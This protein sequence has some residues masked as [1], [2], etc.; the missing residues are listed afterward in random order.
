MLT[1][2]QLGYFSHTAKKVSAN[3]QKT[4]PHLAKPFRTAKDGYVLKPIESLTKRAINRQVEHTR[5]QGIKMFPVMI[6]QSLN[7][8][9]PGTEIVKN[10][11]GQFF[12]AL[13]QKTV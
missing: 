9:K 5:N 8:A 11:I 10:S 1:L 12:S 13:M 3:W 2:N 4:V 6:E 7:P